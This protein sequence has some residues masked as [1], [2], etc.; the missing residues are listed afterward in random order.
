MSLAISFRHFRLLA[1]AL[2]A[3]CAL[4]QDPAAPSSA[5]PVSTPALSRP[6]IQTPAKSEAEAV[7]VTP[8]SAGAVPAEQIRELLQRAE[9]RDLENDKRQ[10]DYTYLEREERHKLDGHGGVAKVES[11]TLEFLEIY[12]E[13]VERLTARDDKPLSADEARKEDEKIQKIIDRRKNESD[14]ERRRR[15]EKEEKDHQEDR[16]FVL[17]VA[18]AFNFRLVGSERIDGHD[19][20]VLEAEPRPGYEAK[21]REAKVLGKFKGRVWIDKA[22]AQWVKL[23]ITAIDTVSIGLVLARIHK[24]T[25]LVV[26]LTRVNDEV[27]LPKR[28]QLHFDARVA[29]FK[30]Y[31]D[32]V[33]QTY[34]DYKKF[35]TD[36]KITV[37]GEEDRE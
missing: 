30:S 23:D 29:L 18:D 9:A 36:T 1:L 35:R 34:R 28:L 16:K 24:G 10:R 2:M 12:G 37:V 4:A 8:D 5:P 20:W 32:D 14:A 13:P 21:S 15:L 17:E 33:E 11:R 25:H 26:E 27:W 19:S 6:D 7:D 31:D 22:E 3:A